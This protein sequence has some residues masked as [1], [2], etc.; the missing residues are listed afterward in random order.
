MPS[1]TEIYMPQEL[2]DLSRRGVDGPAP[3]GGRSAPA[4]AGLLEC[5]RHLLV[6]GGPGAGKSGLLRYISATA[7]ADHLATLPAGYFPVLIRARD[8]AAEMPLADAIYEG[9]IEEL[10][11]ALSRGLPQGFFEA[12]PLPGIP[13]LILV[14][15]L[16]EI[17]DPGER[18]AAVRALAG[19][20]QESAWR[21][22]VATRR[23]PEGDIG[24]LGKLFGECEHR[25]FTKDQFLQ[26]AARWLSR[27]ADPDSRERHDH[28]H[29]HAG[30]SLTTIAC[31][32]RR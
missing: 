11:T 13:W 9:V 4:W 20:S 7:A 31:R 5:Y 15:G 6:Y 16:D 28:I 25:P 27:L 30:C 10:G 23:L 24:E 17:R 12:A 1:P 18:A 8:L 19:A 29:E 3:A 32:A 21:F 26:F 22:V 14:D 2:A